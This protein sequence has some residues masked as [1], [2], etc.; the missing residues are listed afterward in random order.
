MHLLAFGFPWISRHLRTGLW[1][2][3]YRWWANLWMASLL[4]KCCRKAPLLWWWDPQQSSCEGYTIPTNAASWNFE[5]LFTS[6]TFKSRVALFRNY[7]SIS[8]AGMTMTY[9]Q[10]DVWW[11]GPVLGVSLLRNLKIL[12]A[13]YLTARFLNRWLQIKYEFITLYQ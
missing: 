6:L 9:I 3:Q 10:V 4:Q 13:D 8:R 11:M 7:V 5:L 1:V 2:W 12:N